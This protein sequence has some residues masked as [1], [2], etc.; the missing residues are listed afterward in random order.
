MAGCNSG[1]FS[2]RASSSGSG[3]FRYALGTAPTTLDPGKVQDVDTTDLLSNV[4]EGLVGYD[5]N[6]HIAGRI[7]ESW[8]GSEGGRVW[9]FTLRRNAKFHNG[10][11]VAADDVKWSLERA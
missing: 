8:K 9:T 10:R 1:G 2:K 7:A 11:T 5:E 3:V 4:Y 6:N